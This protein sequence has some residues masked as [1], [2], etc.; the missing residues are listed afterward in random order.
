MWGTE[1]NF[2]MKGTLSRNA[3]LQGTLGN[4][5]ISIDALILGSHSLRW[6][7][8]KQQKCI[9]IVDHICAVTKEEEFD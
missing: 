3:K 8:R 6:K 7:V 4:L 2:S 1:I 9:Y 5:Y